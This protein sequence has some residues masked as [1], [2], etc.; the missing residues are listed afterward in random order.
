MQNDLNRGT[1][2]AEKVVLLVIDEAHR[3]T[4]NHAYC[5]VIRELR[6]RNQRFRVLAL[7][8]TPGAD[9]KTVQQVVQ[10]VLVSRIEI[11]TEDSLDIKPYIHQRSLEV[12]TVALSEQIIAIRSALN[13]IM[14]IYIGRLCRAKA[15]YR[16]DPQNIGR[17][18]LLMARDRWRE[19]NRNRQGTTGGITPGRAASLEG[20]FGVAMSVCAPSSWAWSI[21]DCSGS[22][23]S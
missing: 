3:A 12:V 7:T 2:P 11:R 10:N 6:Q 23:Y 9:T 21:C 17:Y 1:C 15:F 20:D 5:E 8:A 22:W 4:G 16:T 13:K 19:E 18:E 14:E